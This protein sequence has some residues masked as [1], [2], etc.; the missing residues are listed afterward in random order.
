MPHPNPKFRHGGGSI[1]ESELWKQSPAMA[2]ARDLMQGDLGADMFAAAAKGGASGGSLLDHRSSHSLPRRDNI[3]PGEIRRALLRRGEKP[4]R[5]ID[6]ARPLIDLVME[7]SFHEDPGLY[8]VADHRG[9]RE[10]LRKA[11]CFTLDSTT[12]AL[13][14]D[15]SLAVAEDIEGARPMALPP[16]PVTWFEVDNRARLDAIMRQGL[17]LTPT[18]AGE[19]DLGPPVPR[20]G[21]LI[22][23]G[24]RD[25]HHHLSYFTVVNEGVVMA[26]LSW[27]WHTGHDEPAF[28]P[29]EY[30]D[31]Y[32]RHLE[33][34][35]FGMVNS[36]MD[37]R[38][39]M[40]GTAWFQRRLTREALD[41]MTE[42][43][44]ELRHV[45]GLLVALSA[46]H[47]GLTSSKAP[48]AKPSGPDP[49][50]PNGKPIFPLEHHQLHLHL[51]S[52]REVGKVMAQIITHHRK[53]FHDVRAHMR[54]LHSGKL[55]PVRSHHRGDKTLGVVT[56][57]YL[58]E[59]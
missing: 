12:S 21:W 24:D 44:G 25:D 38:R 23:P 10:L 39:Y 32:S 31:E 59:R 4:P 29:N 34:L 51:G 19:T 3:R 27:G 54:R 36:G 48:Q 5:E 57:D 6:E 9:F 13:V 46:G 20:V 16:Y 15:L 1:T 55:V 17:E 14:G 2:I 37:F 43:G 52:R 50:Q 56:K 42:L 45:F 22:H 41:Y 30:D 40:I 33:R 7:A 18:A 35:V 47:A 8:S 58:V 49:R 28:P 26:P 11:R 53:R